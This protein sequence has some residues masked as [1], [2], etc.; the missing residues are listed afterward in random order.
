MWVK[1]LPQHSSTSSTLLS[2]AVH[3]PEHADNTLARDFMEV[4]LSD[5]TNL[6]LMIH[7][8]VRACIRV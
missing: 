8:R 2:Y 4:M 3:A 7:G 1:V 5:T 6:R